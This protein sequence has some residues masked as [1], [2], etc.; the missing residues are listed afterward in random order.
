M[1]LT[2]HE[3]IRSLEDA[4]G[5]LELE[6]DHLMAN[7]TSAD[8]YMVGSSSQEEND[9]SINF[10]VEI[11]KRINHMLKERKAKVQPT[12]KGKEERLLQEKES[13]VQAQVL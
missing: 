2:H 9:A 8:V 5:H 4:M 13:Y 10:M 3:N 7:K 6:E 11:N 1:H 12:Q